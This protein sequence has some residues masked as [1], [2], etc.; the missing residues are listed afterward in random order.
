MRHLFLHN[1]LTKLKSLHTDDTDFT[2]TFR[3]KPKAFDRGKAFN[4]KDYLV[5]SLTF[6][7]AFSV[8]SGV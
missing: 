7:L 2:D 4:H 5:V 6:F 8:Y 1:N 3:L